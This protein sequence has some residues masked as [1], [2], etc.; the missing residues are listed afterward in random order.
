M[1]VAVQPLFSPT[2][3]Q[4]L[5]NGKPVGEI[6][7]SFW[8]ETAELDLDDERARESKNRGPEHANKTIPD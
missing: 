6:E 2:Y 8:R 3:F 5:E 1:L 7:R 4:I